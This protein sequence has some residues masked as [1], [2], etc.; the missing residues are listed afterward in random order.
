MKTE[1]HI[2][3]RYGETDQMGVIHHANYILYFEDA[4]TAFLEELGYPYRLIE[5]AGFMSPVV[6]VEAR[7]GQPL[8]YGREA[9]VVT[10]LAQLTPVKAT[11]AYEVYQEGQTIGVDKPC[12][13]G[14]SV[15]C[16]VEKGSF[17]PVSMKKALPELYRRYEE[18]LEEN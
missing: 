11:Y 7:Y 14:K 4:R 17:K 18:A 12:A 9:I 15:H 10:R 5:E 8:V 13:T 16:I 3:L 1:K 2:A 6:S